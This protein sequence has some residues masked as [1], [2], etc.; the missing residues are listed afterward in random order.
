[1]KQSL[2]ILLSLFFSVT[3]MA[4][5]GD[6][7]GFVFEK[8][9]GEPAIF[10][11][12]FL[13]GTTVGTTTDVNGFFTLAK[14]KAGSYTLASTSLGFDTATSAVTVVAGNIVNFKLFLKKRQTQLKEVVISADKQEATTEVR[15]SVQKITAKQ[16]KQLASV[17][18]EPD[19]AQYLQVLP[20]VTFTGDQGGQLYIRGGSPVQNKVLLDGMTIYNPFHS[21]GFFSVFETDIIRNADVYSG[22]FGAQ[23]GGRISSIMDITARDGNKNKHNGKFGANTFG[24]KLLLEGPLLKPDT[25]GNGTSVT[26]ILSAK[27]SY[28]NATSKKIYNYKFD[29]NS[30]TN[31]G[32]GKLT[33]NPLGLPFSYTDLYGKLSANLDN[34]SKLNVFG[35]NFMDAVKYT[36]AKVG[37]NNYGV[38]FNTVLVPQGNNV[39]IKARFNYSKYAIVYE[40]AGVKN[41]L[42]S[43]VGGFN[44]GMDFVHGLEHGEIGYGLEA[45]NTVTKFQFTNALNRVIANDNASFDVAAYF[46]YRYNSKNNKLVIDPSIRLQYYATLS[47]FSPEPRLGIKYNVNS[48]LRLKGSSGVYTQN[49]IAG[50]SDRDV[51]NLFYGFL[52]GPE[53]LQKKLTTEK[54]FTGNAGA[55]KD[56]KSKLQKAI[57]YIVGFEYDFA[58]H[59]ELNVE[60]YHK[61]FAQLTNINRDK[62]FDERETQKP[63]YLRTD[64][65]VE[66]GYAFGT[67]VILKYDYKTFYLW[68]TYSLGYL[69]RWDG[70]Q[71]YA[72]IFDRRHNVNIVS[73][74]TFGKG[75]KWQVDARWN[76]G[77]GFPFVPTSG[78]YESFTQQPYNADPN[79]FAGTQGIQYGALNEINRQPYY[80]RLDVSVKRTFQ[81]YKETKFEA[82]FSLTNAYNRQNL[83]YYDRIN[84]KRVDQLPLLPSLGFT[85]S[86]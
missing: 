10:T 62:I 11:P 67:D 33:S 86:F 32:I 77:S 74:Y 36:L 7:R 61:N 13:K 81:F 27:T 4:Q 42:T 26:Y 9:T 2:L 70:R 75:L 8:S 83:F 57:H 52:T 17:G 12:V 78:Q 48:K 29:P 49:L 38:G 54:G 28:I 20:G 14:V 45:T 31:S 25:A 64:Y 15:T 37:W 76:M 69:R 5:T 41:P 79:A 30:Q 72:P 63:D 80:H 39:L 46:K 16:I 56:V 65:I 40:P 18:G 58:K 44:A 73:S 55:T 60:G 35:F 59:F 24:A 85:F 66:T 43:S 47:E 82:N 6:I 34:G 22:G 53:N 68:T 51:V 3:L 21:I 19:I 84:R 1:M 50:N 71:E 23:H